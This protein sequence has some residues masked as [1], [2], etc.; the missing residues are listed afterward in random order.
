MGALGRGFQ[1]EALLVT[2]KTHF[3]G[4]TEI[5][6]QRIIHPRQA[7][8]GSWNRRLYSSKYCCAGSLLLGDCFFVVRYQQYRYVNCPT[9]SR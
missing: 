3:A 1:P 4:M 9:V 7:A 2:G 5:H 6:Q 8:A